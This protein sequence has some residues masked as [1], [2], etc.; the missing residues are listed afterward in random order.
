MARMARRH[1]F[2]LLEMLVAV[3][4]MSM[5]AASLYAS[6]HTAF[7]GRRSVEAALEPSRR[8]AA[9][10]WLLG[11]DIAAA[12]PPTGLLAGAFQ[13]E[14]DA[15]RA[16]YAADVLTFYALV[17]DQLAG[18]PPSPVRKIEIGL[19]T[20]EDTGETL[21]VRRTTRNLL[22]PEEPEPVGE[23]LCRR[24]RG[25]DAAYYDGADWVESWDS[26]TQ[27]DVLPLAVRVTLT[28][29]VTGRDEGYVVSRIFTPPCGAPA[30]DESATGMNPGGGR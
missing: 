10:L 9:A 27:G 4:L 20:D 24:A 14:D 28:L 5:L 25:F 22:A 11:A 23:I 3:T 7:R 21:L 30:Q 12:T 1:G 15:D 29:H 6:L 16:G 2:T 19:A 13:G 26:T 18:A 8:A 17:A